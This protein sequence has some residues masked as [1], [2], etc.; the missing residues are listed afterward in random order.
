[1]MKKIAAIA[2]LAA[3]ATTAMA[4][5][6]IGCGFGTQV[7]EGQSGVIPKLFAGTTNGIS[8]NQLL[9]I[10]F[11]SLGCGGFDKP[12]TAQDRVN[13]FVDGNA[14]AL[15]RDMA[16]GQGESLNVLAELMGVA[17][18]DKAHFFQTAKAN[19]ADIYAP[20][21]QTTGQVIAAIQQVVA[22]DS[23]LQAY[24]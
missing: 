14:E 20:A 8:S 10:T 11:G 18:Q 15:A 9:G 13:Q 23:T 21:N 22:Q 24:L 7:W 5:A 17:D 16:V 2:I 1:M 12:I 6:D 4:D 3:S 19:F